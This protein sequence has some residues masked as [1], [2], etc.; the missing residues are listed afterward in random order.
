MLIQTTTA[1]SGERM[2]STNLI[3]HAEVKL[4]QTTTAKSGERMSST[5]FPSHLRTKKQEFA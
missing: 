1:K 2:S 4:I 5:N 3:D